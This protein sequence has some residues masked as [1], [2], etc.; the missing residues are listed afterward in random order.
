M[1]YRARGRVAHP[2]LR[3]LLVLA[4]SLAFAGC[5]ASPNTIA[6]TPGSLTTTR[7]ATSPTAA[8]ATAAAPVAR[9]A[10]KVGTLNNVADAPFYIGQERGYYAEAGLDVELIPFDSA[11]QMVAPLGAGQLDVGGGAAGPGLTNAVLRGV[12]LRVVADRN[13]VLPGTSSSCLVVRKEL[14]DNGSVRGFADLRG[15]A[16]AENVPANI[17]TYPFE[18]E[19]QKAGLTRQELEYSVVPF[20]DMVPAFLNG[21]EDA[22][23]L[24][25]P[26]IT[27][28]ESRGAF[29]CWR[30]VADM[31]PGLQIGVLLYGP[32]FASERVEAARQFMVGYIRAAR[33][34]YRA[35][36]GD[37]AGRSAIIGLLT[38][39]TAIKDTALLERPLRGPH[40]IDPDGRVNV[41][42]LRDT[43]RWYL[44]R[45]SLTAEAD[46]DGL[47]GQSFG[48]LR[49]ESARSLPTL[50]LPSA[51]S[52]QRGGSRTAP[53]L[54]PPADG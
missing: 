10:V 15:R 35:F 20:P 11:Q 50:V 24:V 5:G 6:P 9:Q 32:T 23:V 8:A 3:S 25:E 18:L 33:D 34:Y 30:N 45:G 21:A 46:L 27:L 39:H 49:L 36:F 37:G 53:T 29:G 31:T 26:F 44:E 19:L 12:A 22:A 1:R 43:Q 52:D 47:V 41:A 17:L 13:Q 40:G 42:S 2:T 7:A 54:P 14:L 48:G 28:G 38:Q 51:V 16:Y 4:C